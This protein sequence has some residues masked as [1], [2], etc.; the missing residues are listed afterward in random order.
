MLVTVPKFVSYVL[1]AIFMSILFALINLSVALF[2][3]HTSTVRQNSLNA[4]VLTCDTTKLGCSF[5]CQ[6][7]FQFHWRY[8]IISILRAL[9]F[10][11]KMLICRVCRSAKEC[12]ISLA[13]GDGAEHISQ[14]LK[15]FI[16]P[17]VSNTN[18]SKVQIK[19]KYTYLTRINI[20]HDW[21]L[22]KSFHFN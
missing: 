22:K 1:T 13:L 14:M 3:H 21:W 16:D 11:E 12:L 17:T 20:L 18:N 9:I 5:I 4:Y 6:Q 7:F 2:F 8:C 15:E 10:T 19:A